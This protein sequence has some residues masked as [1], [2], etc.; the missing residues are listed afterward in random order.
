MSTLS[1]IKSHY[2]WPLT[3]WKTPVKKVRHK[4]LHLERGNLRID[5]GRR[6]NGKRK[7]G[8]RHQILNTTRHTWKHLF[9]CEGSNLTQRQ[10]RMTAQSHIENWCG[11][12]NKKS[13]MITFQDR[14]TNISE[15]NNTNIPYWECRGIG[16]NVKH[17]P[18][19]VTLVKPLSQ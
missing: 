6:H 17:E 1:H 18:F 14:D 2:R 12:Q 5:T 10:S 11:N 3:S 4:C 16:Y 9:K 7:H 8:F 19:D 15:K 13:D